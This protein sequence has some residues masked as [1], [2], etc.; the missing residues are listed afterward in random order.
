MIDLGA[1][2]RALDAVVLELPADDIADAIGLCAATQAR[3]L[4][5]LTAPTAAVPT[6]LVNA[7]EM[8]AILDVPENW[9]RDKTRADALPH[10]QLGHYIRYD[11]IEVLEAV[12]RLP[13]HDCGF[14]GVKKRKEN[15]GGARPVSTECPPIQADH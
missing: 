6:K 12:R 14:R 8:A 11:P 9:V 2:R 1:I 13:L 10:R 5:R 3:L 15:R 7:A 4:A